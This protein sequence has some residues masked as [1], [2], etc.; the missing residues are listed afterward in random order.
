[1]KESEKNYKIQCSAE[2]FFIQLTIGVKEILNVE[3]SCLCPSTHKWMEL[4]FYSLWNL[5]HFC[6]WHHLN[7]LEFAPVGESHKW[8][9]RIIMC[10]FFHFGMW[11]KCCLSK[12]CSLRLLHLLF[13]SIVWK[14]FLLR[15][16]L[17]KA[18]VA[19]LSF[20]VQN[21]NLGS[22]SPHI[23]WSEMRK[24]EPALVL[25]SYAYVHRERN[26]RKRVRGG[27]EPS[28]PQLAS[29]KLDLQMVPCGSSLE[30]SSIEGKGRGRVEIFVML[31]YS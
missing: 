16:S 31:K 18:H 15:L 10:F 2:K 29:C 17:V 19:G 23:P 27:Q 25:S 12:L 4:A 7:S 13:L 30:E 21:R 14:E 28:L 8:M 24:V 26:S 11:K 6:S 20:P 1:M 22:F 9:R 5:E 3:C